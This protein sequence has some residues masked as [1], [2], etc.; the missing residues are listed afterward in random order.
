MTVGRI[1]NRVTIAG[2]CCVVFVWGCAQQ[3]QQ[4]VG[5]PAQP[6]Q[7]VSEAAKP[8]PSEAAPKPPAPGSVKIALK[9]TPGEQTSYKVT[10]QAHG[11]SSGRGRSPRKALLRKVS[12][13]SR[14]K[15][16]NTIE[17]FAGRVG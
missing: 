2:I 15:W 12:M 17:R 4:P 14:P 6:K 11:A 16:S 10:A 1:F 9:P 7:Q 3:A 8:K 5:P 13:T